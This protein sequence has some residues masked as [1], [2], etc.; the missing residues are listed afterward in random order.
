M[1][2]SAPAG[3]STAAIHADALHADAS[4]W[5]FSTQHDVSPPLSLSTTFSCVEEGHVYSRISSPTRE[6]AEALLGAIEGTSGC[7]AHAVLY[8]SGLA[9]AYA[10]LA[11]LLPKR[12][13][14]RGGYHG[15]HL[16]LAQLQRIS[17]GGVCEPVALPS[18]DRLAA[19]GIQ[20]C[21]TVGNE[22]GLAERGGYA[23]M[24]PELL[25]WLLAWLR[26]RGVCILARRYRGG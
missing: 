22:W 18:P 23:D 4:G 25:A 17:A 14:I 19:S 7:M 20:V 10:V 1:L 5:A 9:A 24:L 21:C 12:V 13:A 11:R 16:V 15:T 3:S 6:R 26:G 8:S 2:C